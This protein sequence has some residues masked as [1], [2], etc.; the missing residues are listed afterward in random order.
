MARARQDGFSLLE[1]MIVVALIGVL[2]GIAIPAT[3]GAMRRYELITVSQQIVSTIRS[4]RVQ[5][6]GRN[7]V[8]RVRFNFPAAGQYQV[9]DS[10]DAPVG[11]VQRLS[12]NTA[13]GA[14]SGNLEFNQAG[15][16]T[17]VGGGAAPVTIVVTNGQ[18]AQ[19]RTITITASGRVTLP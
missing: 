12:T 17:H 10:A 3:A 9:V 7:R 18:V 1:L 2:A 5:A 13:F 4:A 14:V 11:S 8:M 16:A 6:V 19:N 15:R